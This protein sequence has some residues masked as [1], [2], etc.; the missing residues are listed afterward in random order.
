MADR[1]QTTLVYD[2][3]GQIDSTG[4]ANA[5]VIRVAEQISA[6]HRGMAPIRF[7][8]N[9]GNSGSATA[10]IATELSPS[11][12]GAVT[13]KKGGGASDLASGDIVSGGVY[14][15]IYD[16]TFFQVL[17]LNS[18]AFTL[19]DGSV[20]YA[21]LQ[22]ISTTQRV[23]GRNTAGAGDAEE[24][25]LTQL[26][27]WIGSAARGD[28]LYRG[29]ATWSR[30]GAGTAG[31][32]LTSGGPGA[33]PAWATVSSGLTLISTT[34]ASAAA[35]LT[36][37][38]PSSGYAGFEIWLQNVIPSSDGVNFAM[39]V[40]VDGGGSYLAGSNYASSVLNDA[41]AAGTDAS[42]NMLENQPF[43]NQA[44][45]NGSGIVEL[46]NPLTAQRKR[47]FSRISF[48]GNDAGVYGDMRHC[49]IAT[50]SAI[51]NVR[52]AMVNAS[53]VVT[54]NITGTAYLYGRAL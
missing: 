41:G 16:G 49:T 26:L 6:Y 43:G 47:V 13:M 8:A 31:Q 42:F 23:L 50:T 52:F 3:S 22:D 51:T 10:N 40:S 54:G 34:T 11:G 29:A 14:T 39:T 17:E 27:D 33:D 36:I 12:L 24:V 35:N 25:S 20:T 30:L 28:I 46:L 53:S 32:V 45:E 4:S 15:L 44:N 18:V 48:T 21:K 7:K 1:G 5:Y 38:L 37:P 2:S 19:A 9:F